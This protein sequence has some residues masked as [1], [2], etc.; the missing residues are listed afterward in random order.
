MINACYS[1][2][3]TADG[4]KVA[5]TII[6]P[7]VLTETVIGFETCSLHSSMYYISKFCQVDTPVLH[8]L[9]LLSLAVCSDRSI[10]SEVGYA[11]DRGFPLADIAELQIILMKETSARLADS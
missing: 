7:F 5:L 1:V 8:L 10:I 3:C 11:T 2:M 9:H 4:V 6:H